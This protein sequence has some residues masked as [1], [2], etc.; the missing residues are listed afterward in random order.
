MTN[1]KALETAGPVH[2]SVLPFQSSILRHKRSAR[3]KTGLRC[4]ST[5]LEVWGRNLRSTVGEKVTRRE[6]AMV[7]LPWHIQGVMVGLIL[8]DAC[9]RLPKNS[10]N[11]LLRL[12]QSLGHF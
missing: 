9:L 11:A 4:Y 3:N 6:S 7:R 1:E 12:K 2:V 10:K 5:G 8:S